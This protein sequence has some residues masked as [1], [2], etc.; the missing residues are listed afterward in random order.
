M[1]EPGEAACKHKRWLH[2][3]QLGTV[4]YLTPTCLAQGPST[5]NARS[6][7]QTR[8]LLLEYEPPH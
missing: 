7:G 4:A 3:L 6:W 2:W 8:Q 5:D 1:C